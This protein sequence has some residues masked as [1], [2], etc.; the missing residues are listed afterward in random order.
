[1]EKLNGKWKIKW[2]NKS[3]FASTFENTIPIPETN[4]TS[5]YIMGKSVAC[6]RTWHILVIE[7]NST[8]QVYC[9]RKMVW[10]LFGVIKTRLGQRRWTKWKFVHI[11]V[12]QCEDEP[13][14]WSQN[15]V[16]RLFFSKIFVSLVDFSVD[17]WKVVGIKFAHKCRS[18]SE[19]L[20]ASEQ[21]NWH[22]APP[23]PD[24]KL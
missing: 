17:V 11:F 15:I 3:C 13:S 18:H 16:K 19:H 21:E 4:H 7:K 8:C 6:I 12:Q 20:V 2:K 23:H 9:I 1:M 24:W 5:I 14:L 22:L 10:S